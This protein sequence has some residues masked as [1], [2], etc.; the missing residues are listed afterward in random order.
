MKKSQKN[1]T[2]KNNL[3]DLPDNPQDVERLKPE[4]ANLEL[5][6]AK[7]IP[8]QEH[9][10]IPPLGVL[11]DTTISSDDEEGKG[12]FDDAGD[13]EIAMHN[14]GNVSKKEKELL[15][16]AADTMPTRDQQNLKQAQVDKAD[17][18]GELL[19]EKTDQSGR[20]LDVPGSEADDANEKIGEEDEENNPYSLKD[21]RD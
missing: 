11:A 19:N 15:A 7:N 6:E 3:D 12:L 16:D 18:E 1:V 4:E 21:E 13:Q 17:S 8:G 9:I 5:P 14:E 10:H 2:L 20:E